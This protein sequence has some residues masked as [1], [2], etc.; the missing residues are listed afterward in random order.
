MVRT[1]ASRARVRAGGRIRDFGVWLGL[2]LVGLGLG[3]GPRLWLL[4]SL[5]LCLL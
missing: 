5:G 3:L 1:A 4:V 2:K